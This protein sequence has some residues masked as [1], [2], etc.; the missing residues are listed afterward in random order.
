MEEVQRVDQKAELKQTKPPFLTRSNNIDHYFTR[1]VAKKAV[2]ES[3]AKKYVSALQFYADNEMTEHARNGKESFVVSCPAT[4]DASK[5][6]CGLHLTQGIGGQPGS[7]P[8]K[9]LKDILTLPQ[10]RQILQY[11]YRH[12]HDWGDA[13]VFSP[14]DLMLA[15]VAI[16][17]KT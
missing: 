2:Q 9:G 4:D 14:G 11:V 12:R 7:D 5:R 16:P 6:L 1:F 8:H 13:S 15:F 17:L 3:T 10:H